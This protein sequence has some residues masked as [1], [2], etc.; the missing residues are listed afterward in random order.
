MISFQP[1]A[2]SW[3][4]TLPRKERRS[5]YQLERECFFL[6]PHRMMRT[7]FEEPDVEIC[8]DSASCISCAFL[9]IPCS[10]SLVWFR[11][12]SWPM[13][14]EVREQV[15]LGRAFRVDWAIIGRQAYHSPERVDSNTIR[16]I[17]RIPAKRY[18][19]TEIDRRGLTEPQ[20]RP[21]GDRAALRERD[22]A[23]ISRLVRMLH[24]SNRTLV[25]HKPVT[26]IID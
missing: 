26:T 18:S 11:S 25:I 15:V 23:A 6:C 1:T 20:G 13:N 19:R 5:S 21:V 16:C 17:F 10:D 8:L 12:P 24:P 22:E 9:H 2:T 14:V 7:R 3:K 4:A